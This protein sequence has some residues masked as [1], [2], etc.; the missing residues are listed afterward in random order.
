MSRYKCLKLDN[1]ILFMFTRAVQPIWKYSSDNKHRRAE[2][3]SIYGTDDILLH[4]K[5]I[6]I[7]PS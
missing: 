5:S 2:N 3:N 1:K 4:D 7:S 6:L